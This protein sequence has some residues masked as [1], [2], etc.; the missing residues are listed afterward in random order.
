[1]TPDGS[2]ALPCGPKN[3]SKFGEGTFI[4]RGIGRTSL[5][6]QLSENEFPTTQGPE[7]LRVTGLGECSNSTI[8][9]NY[10]YNQSSNIII[11]IVII[12]SERLIIIVIVNSCSQ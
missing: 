12:T 6:E 3:Q 7:G 8:E 10:R 5:A 4:G 1:M 11:I 9:N 2:E